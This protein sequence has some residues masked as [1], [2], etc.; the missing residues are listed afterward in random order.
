MKIA[1]IGE[2]M[3]E[4]SHSEDGRMAVSYGGDTLNTAIYMARLGLDVDYVTALGDDP[5]SLEMMGAWRAEGVGVD[6][7]IQAKG[8]MPG[9]YAIRTDNQGERRFYYWRDQAP[10]RELFRFPEFSKISENLLAMDIIYISGISLSLYSD[11]DRADLFELLDRQRAAGGKVVFD[12]NHRA[13]RWVSSDEACNAYREML[14]RV[15]IALPTFDDEKFL[16]DDAGVEACAARHHAIGVSEV[17]IKMGKAGCFVSSEGK[18]I[19][20]PLSEPRQPK[21]TT[22]AGDSFNA[23]YLAARLNEREPSEAAEFAHTLA[24]EVIM[25]PGAI[26]PLSAMPK[27]TP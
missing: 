27:I 15:D 3:V 25:H 4:L 2:C 8:R 13:S 16:F 24:A 17:A 22:G 11:N 5:Y 14:K 7:V 23:A 19:H 21:D 26:I 10:A 18:S 6:L 9:L 1:C 20:V 12:T